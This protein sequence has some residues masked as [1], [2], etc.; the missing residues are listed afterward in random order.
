MC[1]TKNITSF[2]D[3]LNEIILAAFYIKSC[4]INLWFYRLPKSTNDAW[5]FLVLLHLD[6]IPQSIAFPIFPGLSS[7][8]AASVGFREAGSDNRVRNHT[9]CQRDHDVSAL[10]DMWLVHN[11]SVSPQRDLD[12][13]FPRLNSSGITKT[14]NQP[15]FTGTINRQ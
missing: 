5:K 11:H 10:Q 7:S 9:A 3:V 8:S 14:L 2:Q 12:T 6:Q 15:R 4:L 1:V 13:H